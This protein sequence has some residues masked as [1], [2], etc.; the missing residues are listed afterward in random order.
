MVPHTSAGAA[1]A[2]AGLIPSQGSPL[3]S[4]TTTMT[5]SDM[6]STASAASN[7][8]EINFRSL[9]SPHVGLPASLMTPISTSSSMEMPMDLGFN[10]MD[11]PKSTTSSIPTLTIDQ[12]TG[13]NLPPILTDFANMRGNPT[14]FSAT[15]PHSTS[16][17]YPTSSGLTTPSLS[18]PPSA[19]SSLSTAPS[20]IFP[21]PISSGRRQS[22]PNLTLAAKG[23]PVPPSASSSSA[24]PLHRHLH[25]SLATS[26]TTPAPTDLPLFQRARSS[27]LSGLEL[28]FQQ[29]AIRSP[30]VGA[31]GKEGS[32]T[33]T[34][35]GSPLIPPPILEV[36]EPLSPPNGLGVI[37]EG[38][39][40][41]LGQ[42]E[43]M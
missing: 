32:V 29:H 22:C 37:A 31:R 7:T 24:S 30:L 17:A 26:L 34:G 20:S 35:A 19:T 41:M 42:V 25:N 23:R 5:P 10:D 33:P 27:S 13:P 8:S 38:M 2:Q 21:N 36:P 11:T 1:A 28:I 14:L 43:A 12:P 39:E 18:S 9:L 4:S 16:T 15:T 40:G 3:M 6:T